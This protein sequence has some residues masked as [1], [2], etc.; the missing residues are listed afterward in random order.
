MD[1]QAAHR[2]REKVAMPPRPGV[3]VMEQGWPVSQAQ[4][5]PTVNGAGTHLSSQLDHIFGILT[6]FEMIDPLS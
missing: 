1:H 5:S 2:I 6:D 4:S 3:V